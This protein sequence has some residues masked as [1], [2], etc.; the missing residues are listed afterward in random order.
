MTFLSVLHNLALY[1]SSNLPTLNL[2][3]TQLCLG[4]A[5]LLGSVILSAIINLATT[6][7]KVARA[8]RNSNSLWPAVIDCIAR[9]HGELHGDVWSSYA[10]IKIEKNSLG[11]FRAVSHGKAITLPGWQWSE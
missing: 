3:V 2:T 5:V 10:K 11:L 4:L 8:R 9:N 7:E 6:W 1:I